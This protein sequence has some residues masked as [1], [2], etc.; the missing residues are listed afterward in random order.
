MTVWGYHFG[1][2]AENRSSFVTLISVWWKHYAILSDEALKLNVSREAN[3]IDPVNLMSRTTNM[4]NNVYSFFSILNF[5]SFYSLPFSEMAYIAGIID[6]L[7]PI[8]IK[9][10]LL[11]LFFDKTHVSSAFLS[12]AM[13]FPFYLEPLFFSTSSFPIFMSFFPTYLVSLGLSV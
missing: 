13:L 6:M 12:Q 11:N 8:L 2:L 9:L 3:L 10:N 1:S 7:H 5:F 4:S